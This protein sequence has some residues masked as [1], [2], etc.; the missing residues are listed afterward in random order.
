MQN[1]QFQI[2]SFAFYFRC[3][4]FYYKLQQ[5]Q[6][7]FLKQTLLVQVVSYKQVCHRQHYVCD[8]TAGMMGR[9]LLGIACFQAPRHATLVHRAAVIYSTC[10]ALLHIFNY[11]HRNCFLL[12]SPSVPSRAHDYYIMYLRYRRQIFQLILKSPSML[13]PALLQYR[14]AGNGKA[15]RP[16]ERL[17]SQKVVNITHYATRETSTSAFGRPS[18]PELQRKIIGL[19]HFQVK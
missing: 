15:Q 10:R 14:V 12:L 3:Y 13:T 17:H 7:L 6:R 8:T 1:V 16:L 19:T 4:I 2:F 5:R 18:A 11:A 9:V